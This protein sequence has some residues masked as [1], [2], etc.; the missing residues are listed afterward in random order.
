[1]GPPSEGPWLSAGK[2]SRASHSK[3]KASLHSIDGLWAI[4]EGERQSQNMGWLAFMGRVI[5]WVNK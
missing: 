3:V 1:M 5:S 4:S 2:G